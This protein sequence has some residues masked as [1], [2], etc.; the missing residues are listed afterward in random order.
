M[1]EPHYLHWLDLA[2]EDDAECRDYFVR[3]ITLLAF[4]VSKEDMQ[5]AVRKALEVRKPR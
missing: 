1:N 4:K 2:P 3:L 5:E